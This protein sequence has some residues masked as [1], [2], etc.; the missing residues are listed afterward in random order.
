M[1]VCVCICRCACALSIYLHPAPLHKL[2]ETPRSSPSPSD[3]VIKNI[4]VSVLINSIKDPQSAILTSY[5]V[6]SILINKPICL[7]LTRLCVKSDF[8]QTDLDPFQ[9][10]VDAMRRVLSQ[11]TTA[12]APAPYPAPSVSSSAPDLHSQSHDQS[13]ALLWLGGGMQWLSPAVFARP[14]DATASFTHRKS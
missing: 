14:R 12:P 9:E 13:S 5:L 10:L 6:I 8:N 4:T 7:I 3:L 2:L 1:H 11:T